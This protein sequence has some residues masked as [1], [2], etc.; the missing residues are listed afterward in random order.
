MNRYQ[1]WT[2][3]TESAIDAPEIERIKRKSNRDRTKDELNH[4]P[5]HSKRENESFCCIHCK[6]R[7]S[8]NRE[9]S[10]VNNRNHCPYCL[11]SRHVDLNRPG[12]RRATCLS[13][14]TAIGVTLKRTYKKYN[15]PRQGELM[16]IHRCAGCGK[17]SINR[18][19][20]DDNP[21]LIFKLFEESVQLTSD[22]LEQLAEDGIQ[23]LQ[24]GDFTLVFTQLFG[25]GA[26]VEDFTHVELQKIPVDVK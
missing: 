18:I 21:Q 24:S 17:L 8:I 5:K 13:K 10:G 9:V 2:R 7:V 1:N 26:V 12:D 20:S 14:M 22:D 16:L 25:W 23:P 6:Q 15:G 3:R 4:H 19:A 11:T